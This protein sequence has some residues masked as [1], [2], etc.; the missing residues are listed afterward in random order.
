MREWAIEEGTE[1]DYQARVRERIST[2]VGRIRE[3]ERTR[4]FVASTKASCFFCRFQTLCTRYPQG[5]AV[6]P[7]DPDPVPAHKES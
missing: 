2:L 5:G 1:T 4:R 6:F 3:L 7:I